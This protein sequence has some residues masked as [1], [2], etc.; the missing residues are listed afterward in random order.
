M[1]HTHNIQ[2]YC[3]WSTLNHIAIGEVT[4]RIEKHSK[5][6]KKKKIDVENTPVLDGV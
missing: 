1:D 4:I 5:W 3:S 6:E 2:R